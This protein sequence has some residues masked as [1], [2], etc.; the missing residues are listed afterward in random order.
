MPTPQ[1]WREIMPTSKC[2]N[3]PIHMPCD[4]HRKRS[5]GTNLGSR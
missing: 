5:Q 3:P 2:K 1:G 4:L